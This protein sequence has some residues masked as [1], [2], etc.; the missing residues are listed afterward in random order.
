M[1]FEDVMVIMRY[2]HYAKFPGRSAPLC[3]HD[4]TLCDVDARGNF[5]VV[6]SMN[7][8]DIMREDWDWRLD[9]DG[10]DE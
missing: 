1:R 8:A 4:G 2:G 9:Y 3:I 7:V 10:W 5:L 6:V